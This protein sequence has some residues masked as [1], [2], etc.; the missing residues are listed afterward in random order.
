[1]NSVYDVSKNII[2]KHLTQR[3]LAQQCL[4]LITFICLTDE[5]K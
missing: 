1:M 3:E 5:S 2:H 4:F